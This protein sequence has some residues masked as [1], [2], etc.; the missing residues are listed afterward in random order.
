M[1][2]GTLLISGYPIKEV[3]A[4]DRGKAYTHCKPGEELTFS[5]PFKN[6]KTASLYASPDL[7]KD[8]G[9]LQN[10]FGRI[11]KESG[12]TY[13]KSKVHPR[14]YFGCD[15]VDAIFPAR[16]GYVGFGIGQ[17]GSP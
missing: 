11:G 13:P 9:T 7:S 5:C 14:E 10:R 12:L 6:G 2:L 8:A 17:S 16:A 4:A 1:V 15:E 3:D